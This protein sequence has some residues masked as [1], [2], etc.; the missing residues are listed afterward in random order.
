[1]CLAAI[2]IQ[3]HPKYPLICLANRDEFHDRPTRPLQPWSAGSVMLYSGKDEQSGGTWLAVGDNAEFALLTNVRNSALNMPPTAPSRGELVVNT[4]RFANGP[5][6]AES[7]R[8][9]GYNLIHGNLRTLSFHYS[10]NQGLK[11]GK[12]LEWSWP[13]AAG[14]HTLSNGELNAK[15]PKSTT[16]ENGLN[17]LI[18]TSSRQAISQDDLENALFGLLADTRLAEDADLPSTGVPYEWE[19]MLSAV[20]IVSPLYGTRSSAVVLL[21]ANNTVHFTEITLNP[22]GQEA[23]RQRLEIPLPP[24]L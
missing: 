12:G 16:L 22:N 18:Q 2:A 8:Y 1:M 5:D 3:A 10:S 23:G 13:L 24:S 21:D 15:W 9:A 20:K 17:A 19:K 4:V 14:V 6:S 11:L 7:L